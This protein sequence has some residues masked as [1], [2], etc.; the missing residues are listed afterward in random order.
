MPKI[1]CFSESRI[2]QKPLVN[3][4]LPNYKLVHIDSPTPA[5]RIAVYVS[6]KLRIEI[7]SNLSLNIDGCENMWIKLR[8][9]DTIVSI[10][11][12]VLSLWKYC[13][14]YVSKIDVESFKSRL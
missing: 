2:N 6:N 8:H 1:I 4:E 3:L 7:V 12:C 11:F 9:L 13:L 10:Y 5:G 14:V